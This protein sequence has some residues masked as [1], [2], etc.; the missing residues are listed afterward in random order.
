MKLSVPLRPL[1]TFTSILCAL[2]L[3][4]M[5]WMPLSYGLDAEESS[6]TVSKADDHPHK[7]KQMTHKPKKTKEKRNISPK[8]KQLKPSSIGI[9]SPGAANE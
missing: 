7:V 4:A 1:P 6:Q 5:T 9:A 3:V 2:F 8:P